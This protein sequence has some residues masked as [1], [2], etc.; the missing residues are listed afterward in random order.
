MEETETEDDKGKSRP[1]LPSVDDEVVYAELP[2]SKKKLSKVQSEEFPDDKPKR[3]FQTKSEPEFNLVNLKQ[4]SPKNNLKKSQDN[5]SSPSQNEQKMARKTAHNY[6]SNLSQ[7]YIQNVDNLKLINSCLSQQQMPASPNSILNLQVSSSQPLGQSKKLSIK[8]VNSPT[9]GLNESSYYQN[10]TKS[11]GLNTTKHKKQTL[12]N[13]P[14]EEQPSARRQSR[15]RG[16]SKGKKAQAVASKHF[17]SKQL[18]NLADLNYFIK[19]LEKGMSSQNTPSNLIKKV[20][21]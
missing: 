18:N 19:S 20:E 1:E 14:G 9:S 13:S 16:G 8:T 4:H 3:K 11:G 21:D 2:K 10:S 5:V 17:P 7:G 12:S 6:L 15:P